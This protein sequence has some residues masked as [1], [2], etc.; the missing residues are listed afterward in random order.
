MYGDCRCPGEQAVPSA[1]CSGIRVSLWDRKEEADAAAVS[2]STCAYAVGRY[3]H[4][5]HRSP[6]GQRCFGGCQGDTFQG[7]GTW[8][9]GGSQVT[10]WQGTKARAALKDTGCSNTLMTVCC[11]LTLLVLVAVFHHSCRFFSK[12]LLEGTTQ[13]FKVNQVF[14]AKKNKKLFCWSFNERM[15]YFFWPYVSDF[16]LLVRLSTACCICVVLLCCK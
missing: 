2:G 4:A 9:Q 16:G 1:C 12:Q 14:L 15:S 3:V 11:G 7:T 5:A 10:Q 13:V 8:Q 6:W